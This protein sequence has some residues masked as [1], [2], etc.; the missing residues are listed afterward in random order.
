[1]M[2]LLLLTLTAEHLN[3][4]D[5]TDKLLPGKISSLYSETFSYAALNKIIS[6]KKFFLWTAVLLLMLGCMCFCCLAPTGGKRMKHLQSS[7]W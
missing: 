7:K 1:M 2:L 3:H 4:F 5:E 6:F